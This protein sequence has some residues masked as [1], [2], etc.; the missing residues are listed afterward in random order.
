MKQV[1]QSKGSFLRVL[2]VFC[3]MAAFVLSG[4]ATRAKFQNSTVVPAATG[5]VK[6]T[7]DNNNNYKISI[8]IENL[9]EPNRLP[10][11]QNVYVVWADT[12]NG[13]Q[14]LGQLKVDK[15]FIS[16]KLKASLETSIPYKPTRIFITGEN[17]ASV[18]YPGRYVVL[19]TSSF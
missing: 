17:T 11:P 1:V 5:D 14:S 16:G 3:A 15:G 4:C 18:S 12:P 6:V 13:I 7:K 10:E 9:A 2:A 19:N 8:G